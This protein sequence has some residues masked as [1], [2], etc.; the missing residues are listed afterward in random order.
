MSLKKLIPKQR[1]IPSW[2]GGFG[3][4]LRRITF[5]FSF[6]NFLMIS[7]LIWKEYGFVRDIFL[8]NY[9]VFLIFGFGGLLALTLAVEYT[10]VAPSMFRFQQEQ[11]Y[12]KDRSPL[13]PRLDRIE[14]RL[15]R[16]ERR[17]K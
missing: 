4:L 2:L 17:L 13:I 16:I 12:K 3:F 1:E 9:W 7:G 5:Y 14:E 11:Y 15:K 8:G 10:L 6:I